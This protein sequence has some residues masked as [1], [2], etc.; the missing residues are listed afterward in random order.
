MSVV[1]ESE[2]PLDAHWVYKE[3]A[4]RYLAGWHPGTLDWDHPDTT[5]VPSERR[6]QRF[7]EAGKIASRDVFE[8]GKHRKVYN[9]TDVVNCVGHSPRTAPAAGSP[10]GTGAAKAIEQTREVVS[11][12]PA[13][14]Q[15]AIEHMAAQFAALFAGARSAGV[16]LLPAAPATSEPDPVYVGLR[17]AAQLSGLTAPMV[18]TAAEAKQVRSATV[19]GKLRV[20]R[21]DL[22]NIDPAVRGKVS[23]RGR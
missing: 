17:R 6:L 8:K 5:K 11:S 15:P 23:V 4:L 18:R 20:H 2:A 21:D 1:A 12:V 9:L 13:L 16:N 19:G 10:E 14:A 22:V 7:A 3:D